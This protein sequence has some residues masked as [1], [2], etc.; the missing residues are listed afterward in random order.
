MDKETGLRE[1]LLSVFNK[2]FMVEAGAGA[3]KTTL[4]IDRILNQ[5]TRHGNEGEPMKLEEIAAITFTEKAANELKIRV[6]QGLEKRYQETEDEA[7]RELL[8][9]ARLSIDDQFVGTIHSFCQEI[10]RKNAF[11][12]GLGLDYKVLDPEEDQQ[13][14][15]LVWQMYIIR[16]EKDLVPLMKRLDQL[17]LSLADAKS[18]FD[19][20]TGHENSVI[21]YDVRAYM[22][23][24]PLSELAECLEP[25]LHFFREGTDGE[26]ETRYGEP[27]NKPLNAAE[28]AA[29]ESYFRQ[30]TDK[31]C[32]SLAKVLIDKHD[33]DGIYRTT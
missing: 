12:A 26:L 27:L 25:L 4:I 23:E 10:L 24:P 3:G 7:V 31:G 30:R 18:A 32:I 16:E 22:N 28:R 6:S 5:I 11:E 14:R 19:F 15:E 2:N 20:I 13:I 29:F 33:K 17:E 21:D 8:T 9:K 1:R